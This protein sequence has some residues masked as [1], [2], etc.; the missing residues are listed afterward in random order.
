MGRRLSASYDK[1]VQYLGGFTMYEYDN[2]RDCLK[3]L[4]AFNDT[5]NKDFRVK[6]EEGKEHE[7]TIKDLQE[8]NAEALY[9]LADLLGMSDLYLY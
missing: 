9:N 7:A 5:R 2:V 3:D 6:D 1:H 8:L 4:L